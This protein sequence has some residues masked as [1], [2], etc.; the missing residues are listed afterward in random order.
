MIRIENNFG[1][2]ATQF[3]RY[4][5]AWTRA[6]TAG[7][8]D[9]AITVERAAAKNLRGGG[10][11]APGSYPVPIRSRNLRSSLQSRFEERQ[12]MVINSAVY[13]RAIHEGF[14]PYGNPKARRIGR[15]PYLQDAVDSINPTEIMAIRIN[16]ELPA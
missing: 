2:R 3:A 16:K 9:I 10:S 5:G 14:Q 1:D 4:A 8:R 13:A 12:S 6:V 11:A 15:R 7:L